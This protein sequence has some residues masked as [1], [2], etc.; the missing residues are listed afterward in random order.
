LKIVLFGATGNVGQA[1][2][3]EMVDRGHEVTAASRSGT[4]PEGLGL[5]AVSV[6]V[7]DSAQVIHA[8]RGHDALVSTVGPRQGSDDDASL[9]IAATHNLIEA[10]RHTANERLVVIGGA[11]S[12][13]VSPGV[14]VIDDPSFPDAWKANALAQIDALEIYREVDNVDWT[15]LSP[16]AFLGPGERT[17]S[18]TVGGDQLVVDADGVSKIS[19]ADFAIFLV[20]ELEQ[21]N[22]VRRRITA[23]YT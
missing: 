16:A 8:A 13:E 20:D 18:F 19:Y 1:V 21:A 6:D 23:A 2:A 15:Y 9:L 22:A 3:R 14:R 4:S 11:A 7:T 17:G 10:A 5:E 12:L